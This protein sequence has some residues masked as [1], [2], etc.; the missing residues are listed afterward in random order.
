LLRF[1]FFR[2]ADRHKEQLCVQAAFSIVA[3]VNVVA[4]YQTA[5][6]RMK[7]STASNFGETSRI[8]SSSRWKDYEGQVT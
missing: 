6:F 4:T 3:P 2:K 8:Q 1:Q 5:D 7:A